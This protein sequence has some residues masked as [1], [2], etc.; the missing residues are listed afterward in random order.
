L[1][2]RVKHFVDDETG[3][4]IETIVECPIWVEPMAE[5]DSPLCSAL[6]KTYDI[7]AAWIKRNPRSFPPIVMHFSDGRGTDGDPLPYADSLRSLATADGE[8]L[9]FNGYLCSLSNDPVVFPGKRDRLVDEFAM[10]LWDMSS[11]LPDHIYHNLSA[12]GFTLEPAA[13]GMAINSSMSEILQS[14]D[15]GTRMARKLR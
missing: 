13:R 7:A 15:I 1:A 4:E 14:F 3:E 5:G 11:F 2:Q 10:L 12:E 6:V 9:L 8:V